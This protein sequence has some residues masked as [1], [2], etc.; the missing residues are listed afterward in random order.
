MDLRF[1]LNG[2]LIAIILS[3]AFF[4]C[5]NSSPISQINV[6]PEGVAIKGYD[7]VAY[8]TDMSPVKGMSEFKYEW[9]GAEWRFASSEHLEMFI[10]D[11]E[12]YAPKYGGYCAYAVSQ[13]KT[14]DIDPDSWTVLD[15]KLYLN[16]DKDVQRLWEKDM[17]EYIKKADENW[18]RMLSKNKGGLK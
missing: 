1:R 2:L 18:P 14:A 5:A 4:S 11:P 17:L 7:P 9:K 12:K 10:K 6:T 8:F 16:L 3:I 15:G 13:S